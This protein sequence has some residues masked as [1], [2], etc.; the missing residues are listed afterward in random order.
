MI[1]IGVYFSAMHGCVRGIAFNNQG[2]LQFFDPGPQFRQLH[3][4]D[5]EPVAL[6]DAQVCNVFY[7]RPAFG[8][9][10]HNSK[11]RHHIGHVSHINGNAPEF[12]GA[13]YR[14]AFT[15]LVDL[16]AHTR[17]KGNKGGISLQGGHRHIGH[18]D[19]AAGYCG[20]CVEIG[21]IGSITLNG[22]LPGPVYS[23]GNTV[24]VQGFIGFDPDAEGFHHCQGH[25][26]I[27]QGEDL[28][29]HVKFSLLPG[30]RPDQQQGGE[31]LAAFACRQ[32]SFT[33]R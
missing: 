10:C 1:V 20:S 11:G 7:D 5:M 12:L 8:L 25:Y 2:V 28:S 24:A 3:R 21:G 29:L 32:D 15:C 9:G 6:L 19:L 16:A 26:D 14:Q 18:R 33:A 17:Q 31:I 23:P 22:I 4:H 13:A 30:I 27:G